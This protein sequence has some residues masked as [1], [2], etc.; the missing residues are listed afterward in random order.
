V[1]DGT[2]L[3]G[4]FARPDELAGLAAVLGRRGRGVIVVV[5][6]IG[7]RDGAERQNSV[8]EMAWMSEVSRASGRPLTFAI[9]QSDR[10]PGLWSWVLDETAAARAAG[11]DLRRGTAILYGLAGRTPMTS[12]LPGGT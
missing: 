7:E 9:T 3:P 6:R 10:R 8:A 4:T 2:P 1:H 5:P 12:F 11:A